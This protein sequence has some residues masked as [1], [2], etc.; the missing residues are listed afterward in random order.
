MTEKLTSHDIETISADA[1]AHIRSQQFEPWPDLQQASREGSTKRTMQLIALSAT[2]GCVLIGGSVYAAFRMSKPMV[3]ILA[4]IGL[5][6]NQ[7]SGEPN[8]LPHAERP[9]VVTPL[10]RKLETKLFIIA[11]EEP[12]IST[13]AASAASPTN[14]ST[15]TPFQKETTKQEASSGPRQLDANAAATAAAPELPKN[16]QAAQIASQSS[17]ISERQSEVSAFSISPHRIP[18]LKKFMADA[19]AIKPQATA[20]SPKMRG[21]Q[22]A[23]PAPTE[24]NYDG[25]TNPDTTIDSEQK[26]R[27]SAP[28][29]K[30][31]LTLS[32]TEE[33]DKKI[34]R[35]S[36]PFATSTASRCPDYSQPNCAPEKNSSPWYAGIKM[37]LALD[38]LADFNGQNI[39]IRSELKSGGS[40]NIFTGY[41]TD[42]GTRFEAELFK[43]H[44]S[45]DK[46]A[47]A[48]DGGGGSFLG[49]GSLSGT[50]GNG[51]GSVSLT[52]IMFN[53]YQDFLL[54]QK[55][56]PFIG[57]GMG[58]ARVN[59]DD[60]GLTHAALID[61]NDDVFSYQF[62]G[63]ISYILKNNLD[64]F[65]E[66]RYLATKDYDLRYVTGNG[67]KGSLESHNLGVGIRYGF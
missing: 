30:M 50:S 26:Q 13:F 53:I 35:S 21:I 38:S 59:I 29:L 27:P 54:T 4:A 3:G 14:P 15:S 37:S 45:V 22:I 42:F 57:A 12:K 5:E 48:N 55:F 47:M 43:S 7:L 18:S 40:V 1:A 31:S 23:G 62:G 49:L 51:S 8:R 61:G 16:T 33:S 46:T 11:P 60:V 39:D 66:Y 64:F 20:I 2:I 9:S 44:Q 34:A 65:L 63:G 41:R 25:P 19:P 28:D 17:K 58:V 10:T 6:P 67:L 32:R 24:S 52:G 56:R 36:K